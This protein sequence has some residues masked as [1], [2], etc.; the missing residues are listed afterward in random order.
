MSSNNWRIEA[1]NKF[2]TGKR[3]VYDT[4]FG[5][6]TVAFV[7]GVSERVEKRVADVFCKIRPNYRC[8]P[9]QLAVEPDVEAEPVDEPEGDKATVTFVIDCKYRGR[10]KKAGSTGTYS[11]TECQKLVTD[12]KAQFA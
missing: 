6:I 10:D 5:K 12:G 11:L 9:D 1:P 7:E 8:V 3:I 2:F 4:S